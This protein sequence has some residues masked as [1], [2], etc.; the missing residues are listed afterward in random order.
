MGK[1][2]LLAVLSLVLLLACIG[3]GEAKDAAIGE[4]D[5]YLVIDSHDFRC[6]T[7]IAEVLSRMGDDYQYAEGKSCA[8]DGLD[9]TFIFDEAEF[10]TVPLESGDMISEIYTD[11]EG[12][13]TSKGVKVGDDKQAVL[14]AYGQPQKEMTGLM[15]YRCSEKAGEPSLCF[16][17]DGETVSAFFVTV[18]QI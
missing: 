6:M 8:Y 15:V 11:D 16:E 9:K 12:S 10:Y 7:D 5:F 2:F 17:L 18:E 4:E 13:A 14:D 1:R 3:C